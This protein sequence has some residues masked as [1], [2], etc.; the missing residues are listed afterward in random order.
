MDVDGALQ[1]CIRLIRQHEGAEDLDQLA[2][3]GCQDGGSQNAVVRGVHDELHQPC[4]FA[5]LDGARHIGHRAFSDFELVTHS[6]SFFLG[7]ADAAE[8]RIG[9]YTVRHGAMFDGEILPFHQ[10]AVNNLEI[11][12][13]DV[14]E[15]RATFAIAE[16]RLYRDRDHLYLDRA[17]WRPVDASR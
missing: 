15:C 7:H 11:V 4:G 2:A 16:C 14:R 6:A 3:F 17:R 10:I 1:E 13:G 5:A 12:I 9:E 8:L